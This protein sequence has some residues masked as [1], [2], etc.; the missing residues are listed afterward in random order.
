METASILGEAWFFYASTSHQ[1]YCHLDPEGKIP[2]M[3]HGPYESKDAAIEAY[4]EWKLEQMETEADE[5]EPE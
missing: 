5:Y 1:Y 4:R 3:F 2:R